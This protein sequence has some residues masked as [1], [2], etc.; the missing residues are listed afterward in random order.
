MPVVKQKPGEQIPQDY[1]APED[2]RWRRRMIDAHGGAEKLTAADWSWLKIIQQDREIVRRC[3]KRLRKLPDEELGSRLGRE[4][5]AL[6]GAAQSRIVG[7]L[8]AL[9]GSR[10]LKE[11]K[12]DP[13]AAL[14]E[15]LKK[16]QQPGVPAPEDEHGE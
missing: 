3:D 7:C 13:S 1:K 4:L 12:V 15:Y 16:W 2:W 11:G 14:S 9:E 10:L 6:R 8:R 5:L